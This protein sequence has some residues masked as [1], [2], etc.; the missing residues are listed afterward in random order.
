MMSIFPII[1]LLA[2]ITSR[3]TL[4]NPA[5]LMRLTGVLPDVIIDILSS[6]VRSLSEYPSKSIIPVAVIISLWAAS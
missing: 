4:N 3:L 6:N 2:E 1:I 5:I